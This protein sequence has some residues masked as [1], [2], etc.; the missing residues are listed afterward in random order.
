MSKEDKLIDLTFSS[1]WKAVL[2]DPRGNELT[3]RAGQGY[4]LVMTFEL[5]LGEWVEIHKVQEMK[6]HILGRMDIMYKDR[7]IWKMDIRCP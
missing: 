2:S 5:D 1:V 7:E 4:V 3:G 6:E